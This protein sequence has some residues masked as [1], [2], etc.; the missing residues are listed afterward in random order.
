MSFFEVRFPPS[1]GMSA[2]M[3]PMR[4]TE[5]VTLGSGAEETNQV[6]ANSLRTYD[7]GSGI[8]SYADLANVTDFWEAMRGR[9]HYFRFKDWTDYNSGTAGTP[10]TATDQKCLN[11]VTGTNQGDGSTTIFQLQKTYGLTINP[12][13]R[14]IKK[15]VAATAK[16]SLAG[17]TQ[18]TSAYTVDTTTGLITFV[19]APLNGVAVKAGFEFD[20]PTR[21][22]SDSLPINLDSFNAGEMPT[23][24]VKEVFI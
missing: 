9:F 24:L 7:V 16:V 8:K 14:T 10:T 1:I 17:V 15:P 19:T 2:T 4:K 12:W 5:I 23:I 21:F 11:T 13:V 3:G 18:L 20:V 22:D 6:W